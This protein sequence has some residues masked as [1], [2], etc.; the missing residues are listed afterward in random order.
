[1]AWTER[2]TPQPFGGSLGVG[3]EYYYARYPRDA[4]PRPD[5]TVMN[6]WDQGYWLIQRARRV[7]VSNPTQERA[8]TSAR[9]YAETDEG[10]ASSLLHEEAARFVLSD[11]ELPFRMTADGTIM[12][13]FQSVL[14]WA[15]ATHSLYY[16]VY[17]RRDQSGWVPMWVFHSA[18]YQSMTFRLVVL[19]GAAA[20]PSNATTVLSVADRVDERSVTFREVI[21][22]RTYATYEEA[23]AAAVAATG[24]ERT[25]IV[26]LDPWQAAVPVAALR[27]LHL[28]HDVRTPAQQPTE[29]PWVRIFEVQ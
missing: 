28:R 13:R 26:G 23:L 15:G 24:P 1:M 19:G 18:Y 22:Q 16:E 21:A 20:T 9:F 27:S 2:E 14:D 10:R 25:V 3:P 12:G 8:S 29:S 4:A 5:Y 7:P 6:W 17:Y 11:W